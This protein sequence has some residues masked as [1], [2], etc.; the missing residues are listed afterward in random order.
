MSLVISF[1]SSTVRVP[2][3]LFGIWSFVFIYFYT[4][5]TS[6]SVNGYLACG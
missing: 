6:G 1:V 3:K 4:G 5:K 2:G